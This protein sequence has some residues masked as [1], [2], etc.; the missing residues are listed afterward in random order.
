MKQGSVWTSE[1]FFERLDIL[2]EVRGWSM[3]TLCQTADIGAA[4]LYT[5]RKRKA[6]PSMVSVC[7]ICDALGISL[8]EFFAEKPLDMDIETVAIRM[9]RLSKRS[10]KILTD[11]VEVLM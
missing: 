8:E 11:L 7:Q 5:A 2:L 1:R 10:R 3:N 6:L 9:K 4:T